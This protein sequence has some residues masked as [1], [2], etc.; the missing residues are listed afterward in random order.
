MWNAADGGTPNQS[1]FH[2][3]FIGESRNG[4]THDCEIT[5]IE[6]TDL[7]DHTRREFFWM[8]VL[9]TITPSGLNIDEVYD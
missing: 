7:S 3:H 8:R 6:K 1:Y 5:F 4:L 9:K 2:Q